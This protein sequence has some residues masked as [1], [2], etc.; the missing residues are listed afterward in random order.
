[1]KRFS[2]LKKKIPYLNKVSNCHFQNFFSSWKQIMC[3]F[4]SMEDRIWIEKQHQIYMQI[5]FLRE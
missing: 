1:M 4:N 3:V 2:D 5:F